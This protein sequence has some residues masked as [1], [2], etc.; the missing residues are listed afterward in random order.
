MLNLLETLRPNDLQYLVSDILSI[1]QYTSKAR[2]DDITIGINV[3][4]IEAAHE[5]CQLLTKLFIDELQ[6]SEVSDNM[7]EN[8]EFTVFIEFK[9]NKHIFEIIED[10]VET[11]SRLTGLKKWYFK[12]NLVDEESLELTKEN[13][14]ANIRIT[15][16]VM[17]DIKDAT[18]KE[19]EIKE[20]LETGVFKR[21]GDTII[22]E[23]GYDRYNW[24]IEGFISEEQFDKEIDEAEEA[25]SPSYLT[26]IEAF[27]CHQFY[28]A[29]EHLYLQRDDKILKLKYLG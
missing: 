4:D 21:A 10:V 7:T 25:G 12:T 26:L 24:Q 1:D 8:D 9:R 13:L 19:K 16:L 17:K 6:D 29:D 28:E 5:L 18:S 15:P 2:V 11:L 14:V 22:V 27:P 23:D 20:F 3:S